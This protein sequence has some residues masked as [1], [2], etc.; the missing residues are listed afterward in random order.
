MVLIREVQQTARNTP[1]LKNV[2]KSETI[3]DWE[4]VV[5]GT[6]DKEHRGIELQDVLWGGWIPTTVVVPISPECAVE[7]CRLLAK[8]K[9]EIKT[10]NL[11][12]V[13]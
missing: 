7:L 11:H 6:V 1:F 12:H 2:E 13:Q 5:L 10:K 8:L 3:R 4:T 9:R